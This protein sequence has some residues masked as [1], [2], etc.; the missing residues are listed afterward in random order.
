MFPELSNH[1]FELA[2]KGEL[3]LSGLPAR[4]YPFLAVLYG[5][6]AP[7]FSSILVA[8]PL[9]IFLFLFGSS[10]LDNSSLYNSAYGLTAILIL[11]FG[12]IFFLVGGWIRLFEGR[13]LWTLGLEGQGWLLKYLRGSWWGLVM[14]SVSIGLPALL[15][16][17]KFEWGDERLVFML[18]SA[19]VVLLGW[20][21]QGAAEELLFRGYMLQI[22]GVR[23]GMGAGIIVSSLLFTL[24]H[25]FN[26]NIG[27]ISLMNLTLFGV[28]AALYAI[29]EGSLWG[30]FAVHSIWNWAQASLFGVQVSGVPIKLDAL[31][32]MAEPGPAWLTGGAFGPEGGVAVTVVL[33]AGIL[34]L[35]ARARR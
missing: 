8:I 14:I 35:L 19:F 28:F 7:L 18:G 13:R 1:L 24:L 11:G 31:F 15:G 34:V 26:P 27:P 16:F 12:P 22:I 6:V 33:L 25:V 32:T 10:S 3:R 5:L 21:V 20:I 17:V 29:Q 9:G 23:F 30:V 4:L 2:R